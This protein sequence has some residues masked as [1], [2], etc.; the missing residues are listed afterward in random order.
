MMTW[1]LE[2]CKSYRPMTYMSDRRTLFFLGRY[3][4]SWSL[5]YNSTLHH[6]PSL[7]MRDVVVKM[8]VFVFSLVPSPHL[9]FAPVHHH[10]TAVASKTVC[11]RMIRWCWQVISIPNQRSDRAGCGEVGRELTTEVFGQASV[12]RDLQMFIFE[13]LRINLLSEIWGCS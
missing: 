10:P 3:H 6:C 9:P 13:A 2:K 12:F 4:K 7:F 1:G 5:V 11:S 8:C